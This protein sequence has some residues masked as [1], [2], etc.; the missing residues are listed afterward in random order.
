MTKHGRYNM[1]EWREEKKKTNRHPLEGK[2]TK[3]PGQSMK[4]YDRILLFH[5]LWQGPLGKDWEADQSRHCTLRLV[6]V[7]PGGD[8]PATSSAHQ[9][10]ARNPIKNR[11]AAFIFIYLRNWCV[12]LICLQI[13]PG[14]VA[15][16]M[17]MKDN[18]PIPTSIP[19]RDTAWYNLPSFSMNFFHTVCDWLSVCLRIFC[20]C[21][22][23]MYVDILY[24]H[25]PFS[26]LFIH[27]Y[28][29]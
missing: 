14:R 15:D 13:T 28:N 16:D 7:L 10:P 3:G 9:H 26:L 18:S 1:A 21:K 25:V 6:A 29:T 23:G 19:Y 5:P 17:K 8:C 2:S 24:I 27:I 12:I 20:L 4:R 22:F 11:V